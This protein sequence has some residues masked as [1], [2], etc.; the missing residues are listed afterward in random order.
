MSSITPI[1]S[2]SGLPTRSSD[3]SGTVTI[4]NTRGRL[5]LVRDAASGNA[6]ARLM[7]KTEGGDW[8]VLP[9]VAHTGDD[10]VDVVDFDNTASSTKY[11]VM[12]NEGS[13][14]V[15]AYL[16]G[17]V[18]PATSTALIAHASNHL[19]GGS[20]PLLDAPGTVG[21]V[22]PGV[23]AGTFGPS[24]GNQNT[25]PSV[26]G[27]T[28]ALIAA[29]Q[30]LTNKTLT[31][32]VINGASA[33]SGNFDLS[34]STGT[35]KTSTGAVTV[36]GGAAAIGITSSGA[37]I[38][39]TAGAA[40]IWSTSAGALG[41]DGF[42][43]VNLKVGGT[44]VADV[45]A[46]NSEKL[47]LAAGK[48]LSMAEG[49]GALDLG[50]GTG[51][52]ALPTGS[53]SWA[54]ASGKKLSL[55]ADGAA[56]LTS[57]AGALTFTAA[58]AS[59]WSTSAGA[60]ALA[61]AAGVNLRRG[62]T[63]VLDV[64][65]TTSTAAT[66]GANM[67]LAGAAGTGGLSLGS[68]TGDAALPTG[69]LSWAGASNKNISLVAS[70]TGTVTINSADVMNVGTSG[71]TTITVGRSGQ[72]TVLNSTVTFGGKTAAGATAFLVADSGD[73]GAISV[74]TDGV[75]ALTSAAAETRT[76]AIPTFIGQRL[77]LICDVHAGNI[78]VTSAQAVN[79][80]GNTVMTF[81]AAADM[82][83]LAAMRVGGALRWRVTANDGVA[84][85]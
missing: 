31:A 20:D 24:S 78:V 53:L 32:P 22:T 13:C 76:L 3:P 62:A 74:A 56:S 11:H 38:T 1:T 19:A 72:S 70:G 21:G 85:S 34:G 71:T 48:S 66:L 51:D 14:A 50:S 57:A 58:A 9:I 67:S 61:G 12:L 4:S 60:L 41:V 54:G 23:F 2:S 44:T 5:T 39:I 59:V 10:G 55:A 33:A 27:D 45:G 52:S 35:F 65:A 29:S 49:A 28:F 82:I 68:M 7:R 43:G 77:A 26:N 81:G 30:T 63:V 37:A 15:R 83:E 16:S 42:A 6:T 40:S 75:C 46:T 25:V 18:D 17:L 64:G 79:Q 73:A 36:G 69:A 80:A 47:T 8:E 84:L